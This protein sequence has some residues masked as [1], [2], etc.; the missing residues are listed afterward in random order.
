MTN[1]GDGARPPFDNPTPAG[2]TLDGVRLQLWSTRSRRFAPSWIEVPGSH[3]KVA[4]PCRGV[5]DRAQSWR[6]TSD[7][8][9]RA[10]LHLETQAWREAR[11]AA[12]A[13]TS[14]RAAFLVQSAFHRQSVSSRVAFALI[15]RF[16]GPA[17][18]LAALPPTIRLPALVR[19]FDALARRG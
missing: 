6:T 13:L 17:T 8:P 9:C 7:A 1:T 15:L 19:H 5:V 10:P 11:T 2:G 16:W 18:D 12:T 4:P 14:T 3:P